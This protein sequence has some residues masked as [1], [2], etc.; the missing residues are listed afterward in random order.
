MNKACQYN[1]FYSIICC[2]VLSLF[3][4]TDFADDNDILQFELVHE[5]KGHSESVNAVVFSTDGKYL[6]S[7]SRDKTVKV[8]DASTGELLKTL[9]YDESVKTLAQN[10][11]NFEFAVGGAVLHKKIKIWDASTGNVIRELT[12]HTKSV[13][14]IT[15][16]PDGKYI[17]SAGNTGEN[18]VRIWNNADGKEIKTLK[19]HTQGIISLAYSSDGRH[20]V[21][22]SWDKTVKVWNASTGEL[23][24]TINTGFDYPI[25]A[26]SDSYLAV[27]SAKSQRSEDINIKIYTTSD[28]TLFF[29]IKDNSKKDIITALDFS[30]DER[31]LVSASNK[32]VKLWN[33]S[34][35]TKSHI[36][37]FKNIGFVN[38]VVFSPD[39]KYIAFG[40]EVLKIWEILEK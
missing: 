5:L 37:I 3:S 7:G 25:L 40:E 20:I 14:A 32:N 13:Y 28:W 35:N 30:P 10:P 23:L 22:G 15:Y 18:I 33:V 1:I 36:R 9:N 4:C 19:G 27:V 12:G 2:I 8:W 16:S 6:L 29:T 11:K 39:G 31:Y 34:K 38:S 24:K 17:A 26:L 21:S